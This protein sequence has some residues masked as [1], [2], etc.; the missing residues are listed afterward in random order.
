MDPGLALAVARIRRHGWLHCA[1]GIMGWCFSGVGLGTLVP[2]KEL[3]ML[4]RT[5]LIMDNFTSPES[6]GAVWGWRLPVSTWPRISAQ[7]KVPKDTEEGAWRGRTWPEPWSQ[8]DGTAL[9]WI[10]SETAS[11]ASSP[12]LREASLLRR[13]ARTTERSL[14]L[15]L[16]RHPTSWDEAAAPLDVPQLLSA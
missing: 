2:V 14:F 1:G 4:Q 6:V 7:S 8:P 13:V 15:N 12:H 3:W 9:G 5:N 10:R 11:Q 16:C